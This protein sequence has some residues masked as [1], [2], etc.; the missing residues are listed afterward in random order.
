MLGKAKESLLCVEDIPNG[1]LLT[2]PCCLNAVDM[3]ARTAEE[4][5]REQ[6]GQAELF[7]AMLVLREALLNAIKHGCGF[8]ASKTVEARI[9]VEGHQ[10][11]IV[12]T[13]PGQ[14]FD[15]K[16]QKGSPPDFSC[17]SGR[18]LCIMQ[19]YVHS[20]NFNETGNILTLRVKLQEGNPAMS[21]ALHANAYVISPEG[22]IVASMTEPFKLRLKAA[23]TE[24]GPG[25]TIDCSTVKMIDS[26]GIGLLIATHNSLEKTG[27]RLALKA[28]SPEI[29][30]LL[31]AMRLDKHFHIIS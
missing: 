22:D 1:L 16:K 6:G 25:L 15:W 8:D 13:D 29:G 12:V 24:N 31:R 28:V 20:M 17:T 4:L 27:G 30:K 2:L 7:G 5:L 11:V 18:G 26:M 23:L 21:D 3:A 19:Q 9:T 10:A 14:G